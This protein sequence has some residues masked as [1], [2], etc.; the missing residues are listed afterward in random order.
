MR[1]A[2]TVFT[3]GGGLKIT[4][5]HLPV[6]RKYSNDLLL[7]YPVDDP[8]VLPDTDMIAHEVSNKYGMPCLR[9]QFFGMK[10]ALRCQADFYVFT[11][12]DGFMLRRPEPRD[13]VQ[14][15]IFHQKKGTDGY[16]AS[17]F[18]HFPWVFPAALLEK[19]VAEATFEPFE[20]GFVDRW[21]AAQIERLGMPI[22]GLQDSGEGFSRNTVQSEEEEEQLLQSVASGAYALH[23]VKSSELLRRVLE[24]AEDRDLAQAVPAHQS[25][26]RRE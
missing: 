1:V 6:W 11:E 4:A 7:V 25:R 13:C 16:A 21:L 26:R 18:P 3:F 10:H 8:C 22:F 15:N 23:G 14:A 24:T 5:R 12:Y 2:T 9:R 20:R 17:F 19:F